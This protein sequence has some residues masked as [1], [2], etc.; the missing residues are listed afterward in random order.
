MLIPD[1]FDLIVTP[2]VA[3]ILN[4]FLKV[5]YEFFSCLLFFYTFLL[6]LKSIDFIVYYYYNEAT[7]GNQIMNLVQYLKHSGD[8]S[9]DI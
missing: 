9:R 2:K 1:T 3:S 7:K 6:L 5:S 8:M 4:C